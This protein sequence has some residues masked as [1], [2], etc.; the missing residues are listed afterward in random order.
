[1][2]EHVKKNSEKLIEVK[3]EKDT[4]K[5]HVKKKSEKLTEVTREKDTLEERVKIL[6]RERSARSQKDPN[7]QVI[8]IENQGSSEDATLPASEGP[9]TPPSAT[10]HSGL[11]CRQV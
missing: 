3:R 11:R 10:S 4:L 7:T 9:S 2:E 8:N 6:Q 1:M 5:E